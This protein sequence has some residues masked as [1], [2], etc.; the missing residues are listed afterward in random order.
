METTRI[1]TAKLSVNI[2][3]IA[4]LRNRRDLPWPDLSISAAL[5]LKRARMD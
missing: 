2:N 3:A 1:M 4:Y 5:R